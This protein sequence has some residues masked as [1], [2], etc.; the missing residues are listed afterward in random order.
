MFEDAKKEAA[1]NKNEVYNAAAT[2]PA[3]AGNGKNQV[4]LRSSACSDM[5]FTREGM[6][7]IQVGSVAINGSRYR[8]KD[9]APVKLNTSAAG[10]INAR[11]LNS[12]YLPR[13]R[14]EKNS[15][16]GQWEEV[17]DPTLTKRK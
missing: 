10:S 8:V 3:L 4:Q 5:M 9:G 17:L 6:R 1:R 15:T 14:A 13:Y 2:H 11:I 12:S 7:G 16:T